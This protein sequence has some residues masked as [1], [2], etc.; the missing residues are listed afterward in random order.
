[1]NQDGADSE[2]T[3]PTIRVSPPPPRRKRTRWQKSANLL[4]AYYVIAIGAL[5]IVGLGPIAVGLIYGVLMIVMVVLPFLTPVINTIMLAAI[6]SNLFALLMLCLACNCFILHK[7]GAS[8]D[9]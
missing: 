8:F 3:L 9:Q 4:P 5:F 6:E 1:M 7:I 2:D